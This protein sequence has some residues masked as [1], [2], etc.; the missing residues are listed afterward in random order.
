MPWVLLA[1]RPPRRRWPHH[2]TITIIIS[3]I[4]M[5]ALSGSG[6]CLGCSWPACAPRRHWLHHLITIIISFIGM[7]AL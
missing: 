6:T 4:G 2:L 1:A 5:L 7:L 3:V